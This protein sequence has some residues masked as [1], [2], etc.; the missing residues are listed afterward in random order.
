MNKHILAVLAM[1]GLCAAVPA[2]QPVP[3]A[4]LELVSVTQLSS[5]SRV[6]SAHSK[7]AVYQVA[8][9]A[10]HPVRLLEVS[11]SAS[12]GAMTT[13]TNLYSDSTKAVVGPQA[14]RMTT[15]AVNFGAGVSNCRLRVMYALVGSGRVQ[16][17][18]SAVACK[19]MP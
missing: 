13:E 8:L 3:G 19:L 9:T 18:E 11:L 15:V 2:A 10:L 16:T 14:M 1:L 7:E 17:E 4:S 5:A 6:P 12:H